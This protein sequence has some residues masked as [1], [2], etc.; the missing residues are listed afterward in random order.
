[1]EPERDQWSDD[2]WAAFDTLEAKLDHL[3][4]DVRAMRE[5]MR[6]P[7]P[8]CYPLEVHDEGRAERAQEE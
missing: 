3:H 1:M 5:W 2:L 6:I 4:A 7:R 8:E